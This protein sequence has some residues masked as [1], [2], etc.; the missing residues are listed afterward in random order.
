[1]LR[2][3]YYLL[4]PYIPRNLQIELRRNYIRHK[5][6]KVKNV[7]PID[8]KCGTL[9]EWFT[10]W[11]GG[12]NFA[13]MITHDVERQEGLDKIQNI[14][15]LE[16]K[17]NINSSFGLI[18]E[19]RYRVDE[20]IIEF[21]RN[22]GCEVYLHDLNHDG[23]LF[24]NYNTFSKRAK[25]INEYLKRWNIKGFR[26]G[27][28]HHNIEWIGELD[29][30]Y[31]MSTFDTDPFE[32]MSE[33]C[34]TVFPFLVYSKPFKRYFIEIPYT[35]PQDLLTLVLHPDRSSKIWF[36]KLEWLVNKKSLAMII[37]HPDYVHFKGEKKKIDCYDVKEYEE[38]LSLL[39]KNYFDS[40]WNPI[41]QK[42][43]EFVKSCNSDKISSLYLK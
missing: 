34:G 42:M 41:P 20:K 28:M 40:F 25:K 23:K 10:G 22:A 2:N 5:L 38:F 17:Y 1:M 14:I 19:E 26:A 11:P 24:S 33:G 12:K 7:W 32:P 27:S 43:C 3:F 4:R 30:E 39:T 16:K 13:L 35:L 9:P 29:I 15:D 6:K 31:D 21:V 18:P 8:E 37:I 36:Q